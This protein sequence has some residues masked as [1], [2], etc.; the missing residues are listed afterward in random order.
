MKSI[1]YIT[2]F[3]IDDVSPEELKKYCSE[4]PLMQK[5][6]IVS[7]LKNAPLMA[8]TSAPVRDVFT[9]ENV[10][11]ADNARSDGTYQWYESEIYHFEKYNLKLNDDFIKYISNRP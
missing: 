1:K 8:F 2:D 9:G 10:R 6:K 5:Q 7:Y 11:D 4:M 3:D